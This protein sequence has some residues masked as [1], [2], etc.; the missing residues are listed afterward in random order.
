M[1]PF[2]SH[3]GT[4]VAIQQA[5]IDTDQI[6]PKQ[7]LK[8]ITKEGLGIYLFDGW[9]YS[10]EGYSGKTDRNPVAHFPLHQHPDASVL[11]AL[12]NFG[13]G[14]SREH[15]VW[16]LLD[17][18]IKVVIAPSFA[19]IFFH[20]SIKNGLLPL[21]LSEQQVK[22]LCLTCQQQPELVLNIS[23]ETM[24]VEAGHTAYN[25]YLDDASRTRLLN[26][27]DGID[28]TLQNAD[29]IRVFEEQHQRNYPWL[30][31]DIQQ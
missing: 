5:N 30:F 27:L 1:K 3:T 8:T 6:I 31:A 10:D 7:F 15:A 21:V 19:D 11:L 24:M 14:S 20:N 18:G 4:A 2:I 17:Y 29:T 13:C 28:L 22:E 9:R 25:F 16:S 12:E 26:G 23:L